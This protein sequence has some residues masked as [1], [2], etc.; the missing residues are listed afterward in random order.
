MV[1]LMLLDVQKAFHSVDHEHLCE[2]VRLAGLDPKWFESYLQDRKQNVFINGFPSGFETIKTGVPQGSILGPWFY[3]LYSNDIP[4]CINSITTKMLLYAD[5]TILLCSGKDPEFVAQQLSSAL[6]QCYHWFTNNRLVM[7][8]GKTES[9]LIT[10]K[11]KRHL[12][13]KF[14]IRNGDQVI[15]PS[16]SV[17][18]LGLKING[19]LSSQEIVDSVLTKCNSRLK[20]MYR[21]KDTL[22]IKTKKLL[23]SALI[24]CHFDFASTAWYFSLSKHLKT[25]LQ[26][27]QNKIVRYILDLY[28]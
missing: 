19:T 8:S 6:L 18:Y 17:K 1:G 21:F 24:Q 15:K 20:F 13:N 28:P 5:D 11:N 2:K 12:R 9:I 7:H 26:I 14:I 22:D 3:L 25:R 4:S 10:S 27:A 23:T 16:E